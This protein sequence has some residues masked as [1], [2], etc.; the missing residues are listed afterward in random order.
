MTLEQEAETEATPP[1][2]TTAS[3][4]RFEHVE[5][6]RRVG[7]HR[8][9]G[10]PR[11]FWIYL[12]YALLATVLLT[13]AGIIVVQFGGASVTQLWNDEQ[14]QEEPPPP[15]A[16]DPVLDPTAEVVVLNG[17]TMP[18]FAAIVDSLI[19]QNQW[20]SILFS[21]DADATDVEISAV[22]YGS[23]A[24]EATALGLA[25]ELGGISVYQSHDYLQQYGARL[26][27]LLG[28]D[29]GGPGSDQLML[30]DPAAAAESDSDAESDAV[31]EES[32]E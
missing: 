31:E 32:A 26:V 16:V 19:T 18:G 20:G 8:Y 24:D 15:P 6:S 9:T 30:A 14:T 22:F 5:R 10:K 7:A 1:R 25:Q 23:V 11:R 29:Y 2:S 21:G 27:V 3:R 17:T 4:D 13:G 12:V 28:A